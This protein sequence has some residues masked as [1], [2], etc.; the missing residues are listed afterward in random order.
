MLARI[1]WVHGDAVQMRTFE[2]DQPLADFDL[3]LFGMSMPKDVVPESVTG[4]LNDNGVVIGP[5]CTDEPTE[6]TDET[7]ERYCVGQW[8]AYRKTNGSMW[9]VELPYVMPTRFMIPFSPTRD[10]PNR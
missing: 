1:S 4:A 9:N 5:Q 6:P 2:D 7:P 8:R 10:D 3:I